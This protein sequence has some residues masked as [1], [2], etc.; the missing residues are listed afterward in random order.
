MFCASILAQTKLERGAASGLTHEVTK[1]I[2]FSMIVNKSSSYSG[3]APKA[4]GLKPWRPAGGQRARE[5]RGRRRRAR[6]LAAFPSVRPSISA[7]TVISAFAVS[8][9]MRCSAH[10]RPGSFV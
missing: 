3:A 6:G 9:L 8:V 10:E 1:Q 7:R 2:N 5:G 4:G